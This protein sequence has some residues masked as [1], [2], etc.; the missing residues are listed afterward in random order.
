MPVPVLIAVAIVLLV[1]LLFAIDRATK[2]IKRIRRRREANRRL[3]AAA[4]VAEAKNRQRKAAAEASNSLT[5]LIPAIQE[6]DIR[7]VR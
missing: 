6:H 7:H 2:A 3:V 4:A 5:S 1:G